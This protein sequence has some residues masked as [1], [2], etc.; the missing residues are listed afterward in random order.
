MRAH[1]LVTRGEMRRERSLLILQSGGW[2]K[3]TAE[4]V[5]GRQKKRK[6]FKPWPQIRKGRKILG[7]SPSSGDQ[8]AQKRGAGSKA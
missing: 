4:P 2:S 3:K 1:T 7:G 5:L 8:E 6:T